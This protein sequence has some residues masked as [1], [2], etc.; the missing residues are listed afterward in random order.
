MVL[1]FGLEIQLLKYFGHLSSVTN[2]CYIML[3]NSLIERAAYLEI[4]SPLVG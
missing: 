3:Y 4:L 2:V 1:F